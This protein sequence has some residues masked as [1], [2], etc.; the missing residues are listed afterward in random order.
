[1]KGDKRLICVRLKATGR[2]ARIP[3]DSASELVLDN[4]ANYIS[5]SEWRLATG[6]ELTEAQ[7]EDLKYKKH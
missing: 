2:P 7:K 3:R 5:R 4:Q 1:V 6:R